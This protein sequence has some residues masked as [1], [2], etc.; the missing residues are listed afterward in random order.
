MRLCAGWG[1]IFCAVGSMSC[2]KDR[3]ASMVSVQACITRP[4]K[5]RRMIS[6]CTALQHG[7]DMVRSPR[8]SFF[9]HS[10]LAVTRMRL[11][12]S[13]TGAGEEEG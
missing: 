8:V 12:R 10:S 2:D 4:L 7:C 5:R 6:F 9:F 3:D 1:F 11:L 13:F